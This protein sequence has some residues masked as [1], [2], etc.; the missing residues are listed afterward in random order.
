MSGYPKTLVEEDQ[1]LSISALFHEN[2]KIRPW[3]SKI[4][5]TPLVMNQLDHITKAFKTYPSARVKIELP[6]VRPRPGSPIQEVIEKRRSIREFAATPLELEELAQ[7]LHYSYG[8]TEV[9]RYSNVTQSYRASPSAGGLYPLEIY[10][11]L[12]NVN[13]TE[14]GIYHYNVLEH[15]LESVRLGDHQ[16][17]LWS[18]TI[19]QEWVQ[20][21]SFLFVITGIPGR[22]LWKYRERGYRYVLIE[23]GHVAQNTYLVGTAMGI[24]ICSIGGFLDDELAQF[25]FLDG[26]QEFPIYIVG[27]G[28][29]PCA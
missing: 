24:G 18:Y 2:T 22:L 28:K 26:V 21:T 23:A 17:T 19:R 3:E 16:D 13:G 14:P 4:E 7:L 25:M 8:I 29:V 12:F 5:L 6:E 9:R 27:G 11:V 10:P 20:Q 15:A 1:L